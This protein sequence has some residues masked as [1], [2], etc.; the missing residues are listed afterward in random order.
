MKQ[1]D[2][3]PVLTPLKKVRDV[4]GFGSRS[5]ALRLEADPSSG[6][7]QRVRIPG[8]N[9]TAYRTSELIEWAEKCERVAG[10]R[11]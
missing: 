8:T 11:R 9:L 5:T 6:F 2:A 4:L 7:P 10:G 3:F 1:T